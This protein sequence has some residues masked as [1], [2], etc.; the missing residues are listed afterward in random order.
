MS[1]QSVLTL[2]C[3]NVPGIVAAVSV[4]LHEQGCD[5][6]DAQQYDDSETN[7]F[8]MRVVFRLLDD[9]APDEAVQAGLRRLPSASQCRG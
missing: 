3:R 4:Y 5:I 8:F 9:R 2:S 1:D 6:A 7:R